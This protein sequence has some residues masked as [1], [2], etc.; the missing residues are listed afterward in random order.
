MT[1][2]QSSLE[3]TADVRVPLA[4]FVFAY[5]RSSGPGGQNVNKV[6]SQAQL[7]WN[8]SECRSLPA[9]ALDRLR[10]AER[11]RINREDVLRVNCQRFRDRERNRE[12]CLE[13]VRRMI[14]ESLTPPPSR[15]KT[16]VPRRA[17]ESRL[18]EKQL[19]GEAKRSR[20][21]PRLEE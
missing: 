4:E 1:D 9:E 10:I 12:D 20:R 2:S 3:V 5:V 8:L 17:H 18:R 11:G 21:A 16:R 19:R 14:L 7:S 13:R 6:N 15:R